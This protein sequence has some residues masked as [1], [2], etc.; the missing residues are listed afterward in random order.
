MI[1]IESKVLKAA[2]LF[3]AKGDIRYYLN[4]IH[5]NKRGAVEATDGHTGF[6]VKDETLINIEKSIIIRIH[7]TIPA[8]AGMAYIE[9]VDKDKGMITFENNEVILAFSIIDGKFPDMARVTP[10]TSEEEA[11][12][13]IGINSDYVVRIQKA[14]KIIDKNY[15]GMRLQFHG[16][17]KTIKVVVRSFDCECLILTMPMRL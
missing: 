13:E 5:L 1:T 17:N 12:K 4:G 10:K 14:A 2:N 15:K 6:T 16:P 3:V 8:K 9:V 7:G 11:V